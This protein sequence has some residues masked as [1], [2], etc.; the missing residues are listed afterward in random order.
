[1]RLSVQV[2]DPETC[3]VSEDSLRTKVQQQLRE[4]GLPTECR[5]RK[6]GDNTLLSI[7]VVVADETGFKD[8]F[9]YTVKLDVREDVLLLRDPGREVRGASTYSIGGDMRVPK[10][11]GVA[12][13]TLSIENDTFSVVRR[14]CD[15]YAQANRS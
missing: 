1:M 13:L 12:G 6:P 9:S 3:G 5:K 4:A 10:A 2:I 15:D 8:V 7:S 11:G 14:F